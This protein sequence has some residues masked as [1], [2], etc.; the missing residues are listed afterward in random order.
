MIDGPTAAELAAAADRAGD[1]DFER[2]VAENAR[3]I[4]AREASLWPA[5]AAR[6][7]V[8]LRAL[9]ARDGN[10]AELERALIEMIET[11]AIAPTDPA[12][13]DHLRATARDRLAIDQPRYVHD[14]GES[15]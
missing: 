13:L 8:R 3:G 9:T 6:A 14:L 10:F 4:V 1:S 7:V 5:A 15:E 12:L 11:R 2:R